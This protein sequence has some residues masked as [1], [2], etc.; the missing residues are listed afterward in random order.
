MAKIPEQIDK[1]V[2]EELIATGG[3]GAIFKGI[4]PTLKRS[5]IL[6]KLTLRGNATITERFR[7]EASILMDF[8]NDHI[9]DVQ[10]HFVQGRSH[11]IVMEYVDGPSLK[12]LLDEQR[13][14]DN[15]T[16]AYIALYTAK[17][18][19]YAHSKGVIHR[20]IKPGNIL[21][22]RSG[23]IK[24]ADFG[25]AATR[26][27]LTDDEAL[28]TDGMTLGTPAYMAPEQFENS[29]T[30]D[31]R[32]DI[33]SLG[34]MMYEMLT[35]LRPFPGGFT[36]ETINLIQKGKYKQLRK[37]IP[38][39]APPLQKIVNSLIKPRPKSRLKNI[40]VVIR[41]LEAWLDR[42]Q[43]DDIKARLCAMVKEEPAPP[44]RLK[45]HPKYKLFIGIGIAVLVL[46]GLIVGCCALTQIHRR[47]LH[48]NDFGQIQLTTETAGRPSTELFI[49]DGNEIPT[50]EMKVR[51]F[52]VKT[53]YRSLYIVLPSG[54]YRAKTLLGQKVI[55]SSF[56]LE[57]WSKGGGT[58]SIIIDRADTEA[59]EIDISFNIH[60]AENGWDLR[61]I[62]LIELFRDGIFISL[63][64]AGTPMSG[65]V[66]HFRISAPGYDSQEFI[67]KINKNESALHFQL[68]L[69]PKKND[70][71]NK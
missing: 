18:L 31:Y 56:T 60:D 27:Q 14:L 10:D 70:E 4:H 45:S 12:E 43:E 1:Y 57:P 35:G 19:Q 37:I 64:D 32:A 42:Y 28:T 44:V 21:I 40:S 8:R 25:I 55:W 24:L 13:Y 39:I 47:L 61:Q 16:A 20:D 15:Y 48:P 71:D 7:R 29:R 5:I 66:H 41:K 22:S 46:S 30:V 36:P 26:D 38:T 69:E 62:G 6:K 68:E 23:D 2:I 63:T 33:Y 53:N 50:I 54:K 49:D 11:Y 67:L 65:R 52:P 3:M 51:Y 58:K 17:A 34:I 9:V 59:H